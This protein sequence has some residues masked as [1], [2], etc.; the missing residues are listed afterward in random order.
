MRRTLPISRGSSTRTVRARCS[1]TSWRAD[2]ASRACARVASLASDGVPWQR[3][4]PDPLPRQEALERLARSV[5]MDFAALVFARAAGSD[6]WSLQVQAAFDRFM[7]EGP[8]RCEDALRQAGGFPYTVLFVPSWLHRSHPENGADFGRQ[9]RLLERLRIV[10]R[11]VPTAE[12]GSVEDNAATIAEAVRA[13]D[14]APASLV[15]VSASK[16]GAE[17]AYALTRLLTAREASRVASWVNVAGALH[18]TPLADAALRWPAS[19]ITRFVFAIAGW[20]WAGL[21][22]MAT[23]PSRRRIEGASLPPSLAVVNL[24]AI[25]VSG[26]VGSRVFLGY[27]ILKRRGPNDGVVLLADTVWPGGANIVALGADHLFTARQTDADGMAML[28]TIDYVVQRH[29]RPPV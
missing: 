27:E 14:D 3:A 6:A 8:A 29:R 19:W 13:A 15:V 12:S 25:P 16:S 17:V 28:R 21:A 20:D 22:S 11:L 23:E 24:V 2:P 26:S 5:S 10:H 9:R 18:G 4:E 1:P 7:A